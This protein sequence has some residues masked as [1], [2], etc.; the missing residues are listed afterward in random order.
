MAAGVG[1]LESI[2]QRLKNKLPSRIKRVSVVFTDQDG[3]LILDDET[4]YS[5]GILAIPEPFPTCED[6]AQAISEGKI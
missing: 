2:V 3:N 6:W 5:K 1:A 4:E